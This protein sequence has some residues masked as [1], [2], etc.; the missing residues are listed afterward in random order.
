MVVLVWTDRVDVVRQ[1]WEEVGEFADGVVV[2][3]FLVFGGR[4]CVLPLGKT[5]FEWVVS[6]RF[7]RFHH[8]GWIEGTCCRVVGDVGRCG[9]GWKLQGI[10]L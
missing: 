4:R 9:L 7:C 5:G 10:W 8:G 2:R 3:T 1:Y 6:G